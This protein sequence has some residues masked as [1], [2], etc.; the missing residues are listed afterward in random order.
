MSVFQQSIFVYT[1]EKQH[2]QNRPCVKKSTLRHSVLFPVI[3]VI[4][5]QYLYK[6]SKTVY[7]YKYIYSS[8]SVVN[9]E[10]VIAGWDVV[11]LCYFVYI[12]MMNIRYLYSFLPN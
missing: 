9:F 2:K 5:I 7:H 10:H 4:P 3:S 12:K 8:V 6:I 1:L 11:M